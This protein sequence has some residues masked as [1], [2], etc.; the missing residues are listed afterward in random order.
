MQIKGQKILKPNL[1]LAID[2]TTGNGARRLSRILSSVGT[3][4]LTSFLFYLI[5]NDDQC[6]KLVILSSHSIVEIT[7][8]KVS[9]GQIG[10]WISVLL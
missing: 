4:L 9:F 1:D 7:L 6:E 8:V 2:T 5:L 10:Y 3:L